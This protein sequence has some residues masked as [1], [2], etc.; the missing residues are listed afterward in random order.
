MTPKDYIYALAILVTFSLGVWNL[1]QTYRATRKASYINTVT[2]Q[3]VLWIEQMRQDV[4]KFVGLT[5]TWA[6]SELEGSES[7]AD[8]LKEIDRLRYVIRLRLNPDDTPDLAI[9]ALIE[10][11][12]KLTHESKRDELL[13]ALEK[14]TTE[15][16]NMLKNEWEKVKEESKDGDIKE[17]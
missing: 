4:S 12:P 2:S 8:L 9:A 11:I 16:Q 13:T 14:L 10:Q 5:H 6:M 17:K 1:I 7:E 15:T 3:R